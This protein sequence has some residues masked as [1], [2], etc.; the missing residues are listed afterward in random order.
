[1]EKILYGKVG[2]DEV[3]LFKM[4]N[5]KGLTAEIITYGGIVRTLC[6]DG[7]DVV[8]GRDTLEEYMENNGCYGALIGRNSNRIAKGEFTLGGKTYTLAKNNGNNNLHGGNVGF[9]KRVWQ[10]KA[11]DK[12][13]P[14]LILTLTSE[15]G[16]EG[17]PGKVK[18][19]VTYNLTKD[20]GLKIHYEGKA[21]ADT[22]LN[23]TNHTYFNLNGHDSGT[24]DGHTLMIQSSFYTPN[25]DECMPYG[26]VEDVSGSAFDFRE[27]KKMYD[28]FTSGHPQVELFGGY[29]HNFALD[30]FGFRKF[31]TLTGD[32]TGIVMDSY[33]DRPAVQLY[34]GNGIQTE[35]VCKNGAKYPVHGGLCLETQVFPN[36]M[37]YSHF[38]SP[39]LK[40]GEEYDTV[41]EYRFH[42]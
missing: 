15:D 32:K 24:V 28:G 21:N 29:D 4:D 37:E 16:D 13:E 36:A 34:T 12:A 31:S 9:G 40:K 33:T 19:K 26:V 3:Y 11:V 22:L 17:F 14:S 35:R 6:Y 18:V 10:G 38:P 23:M 8:L 39:V 25:T 30:G 1:M 7:V 42:R 41:T 27:G 2:P 5:G 20:N